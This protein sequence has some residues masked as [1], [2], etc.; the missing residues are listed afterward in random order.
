M[1]WRTTGVLEERLKFLA[2][3][4]AG[5]DSVAELARQFGV[6]RKTAHKFVTRYAAHGLEGLVD[7]TRAPH[8]HRGAIAPAVVTLILDGRRTH[9]RWGARKLLPYLARRYPGLALPSASTTSRLLHR[10]GLAAHRVR[11]RGSGP[12][13]APA[14]ST[15]PNDVWCADFKGWF[16]AGNGDRCEPLTITD[17]MSRFAFACE[18]IDRPAVRDVR[19]VFERVFRQ[20]GLPRALRTDNG[21][22]FASLG[23]GG[24]TRL[25]AW[26]VRLG[27]RPD[28]I[29]PGKPQQNGRHERFHLTLQEAV[30]EP[31]QPT[32][33]A[34]QRACRDFL[35]EYN[36]ERP[37]E[38]LGQRPPADLYTPSP[39]PYPTRL[40]PLAY[41][42]DWESR[43]IKPDGHMNWRGKLIYVCGS[44]VHERIGLRP[45]ADGEWLVYFG[46]LE[47]AML[48]ERTRKLIPLPTP[49]W[50][51]PDQPAADLSPMSGDKSVTDVRP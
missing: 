33:V 29:A 41:P 50:R 48:A 45:T 19:P 11:R 31:P 32:R 27:I 13:A 3:Y 17:H 25:S 21:L 15:A 35:H 43:A 37:H 26:W 28:R 30:A 14:P 38:S 23:L 12:S 1:P 7:R 44:L 18:L 47:L 6:S 8:T 20:Y 16:R 42:A 4:L 5:Q 46:P 40:E 10:H 36:Y 39:R 24:L 22:P 49:H 51:E 9:P 34:Q 2:A